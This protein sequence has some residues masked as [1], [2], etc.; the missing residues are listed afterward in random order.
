[1]ERTMSYDNINRWLAAILCGLGIATLA[2]SASAQVPLSYGQYYQQQASTYGKSGPPGQIA[3]STTKATP[4]GQSVHQR[5]HPTRRRAP[6]TS[7][8]CGPSYSG[9]ASA[10]ASWAYVQQRKLE[11]ASETR[12]TRR[13]R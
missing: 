3:T 13:F 12:V 7:P 5:F 10:A 4:P 2:C 8:M 1:M 11:A 9:A 6:P